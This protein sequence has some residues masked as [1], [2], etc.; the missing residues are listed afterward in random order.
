MKN[1]KIVHISDIHVGSP[2]FLPKVM[3]KTIKDINRL[4]PDVVL[5][6]GDLTWEGYIFE[7]NLV[8]SYIDKI[9]CKNKVIVPGNHDSRNV[10]YVHFEDLFGS[11]LYSKYLDDD[12]M[13]LGMDS[14]APDI[15]DGH[16]GRENYGFIEQFFSKQNVFKIFLMHHH[17]LPVPK[18]GR[19]R[20][21]L[22]DAGDVLDVLLKSKV[23]LALSGHKHVPHIWKLNGMYVVN[24]GTVSTTR[25]RGRGECCYYV[26]D[27]GKRLKI[28]KVNAVS[29]PELI[30]DV[31][32]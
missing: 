17:L 22:V 13:V 4:N 28:T 26:I 2:Y 16:V 6:S 9:K 19:E 8:K 31:S 29:K 5:I 15:D 18:S 11:R 3:N 1:K 27:L 24:N 23:D 10:G 12:L 32:K 25:V 20:N 14:S 30:L 21:I 7:Y